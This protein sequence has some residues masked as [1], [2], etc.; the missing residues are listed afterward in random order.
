MASHKARAAKQRIKTPDLN[1]G[2]G[3]TSRTAVSFARAVRIFLGS[4]RQFTINYS[5]CPTECKALQTVRIAMGHF[6][7]LKCRC[8]LF[9]LDICL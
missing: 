3:L 8:L 4:L 5:L 1:K 2:P 6:R 9:I 7:K